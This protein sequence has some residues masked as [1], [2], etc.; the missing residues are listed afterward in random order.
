MLDEGIIYLAGSGGVV[1]KSNNSGLNWNFLTGYQTNLRGIQFLNSNTGYV[2]G[3]GGT[4]LKTTNS[5]NNWQE[6]N[7]GYIRNLHS[8]YFTDVNTGYAAGDSGIVIKTSNGGLNWFTQISG[9]DKNL[10]SICFANHSIGYATGGEQNN[11]QGVII[12]T[13][14]AGTNWFTQLSGSSMNFTSLFIHNPDSAFALTNSSLFKTSNGGMNW[15]FVSG[16]EGYDIQFTN[17]TTGYAMGSNPNVYKTTNGGV[18]WF[19][20]SS[21]YNVAYRSIQFFGEFGITAG[22]DGNIMKTTNGGANWIVLPFVT[23]NY[24]RSLYFTD[25][26]TG[27]VVGYMGAILKTTNGGLSFLNS[28]N[29]IIPKSYTL[30]QNYPNPFN[31]TT[32]F[33]FEAPKL[34]SSL[35]GEVRGGYVRLITYNALGQETGSLVNEVL[36]P[37]IYKVEWNGNDL[38]SGIYFYRLLVTDPNSGSVIHSDSKKMVMIK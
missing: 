7:S 13:T 9:T 38:A 4:I 5:G 16:V 25:P 32:V 6:I 24:L 12:K 21:G 1:L 29:E 31:A 8:L 10:L 17:A 3:D 11:G 20:I 37:G 18:N 26:N 30:H 23:E 15:D 36:Q 2:S 19:V 33:K 28:I 22:S 34:S 27:Y 14:N 35:G